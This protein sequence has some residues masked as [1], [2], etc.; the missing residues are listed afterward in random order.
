M[1][2]NG[3]EGNRVHSRKVVMNCPFPTFLAVYVEVHHLRL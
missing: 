3:S 2:M 1:H